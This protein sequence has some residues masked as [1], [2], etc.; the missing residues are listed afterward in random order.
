MIRYWWVVGWTVA[1]APKG[2]FRNMMWF[3]TRR[4]ARAWVNVLMGHGVP[5]EKIGIEQRMR[6]DR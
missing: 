3:D 1:S 5:R 6:P 4:Q 2:S